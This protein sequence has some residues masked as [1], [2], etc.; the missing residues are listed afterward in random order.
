MN[1]IRRG[2]LSWRSQPERFSSPLHPRLLPRLAS[3]GGQAGP[4]PRWGEG[5][6]KVASVSRLFLLVAWIGLS[7]CSGCYTG[8]V[9][10]PDLKNLSYDREGVLRYKGE[11]VEG[12]KLK[13]PWYKEMWPDNAAEWGFTLVSAGLSA[14]VAS[15]GGGGGGGGG[16]SSGSTE[17]TVA[18]TTT[19]PSSGGGGGRSRPSTQ[20]TTT[21][22]AT[23]DSGGGGGGGGGGAAPPPAPEFETP[24][25]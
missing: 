5:E 6:E 11:E 23:S 13:L 18:T 22:T 17:P 12:I 10:R 9:N 16:S 21:S 1:F 14:A 2:G 8:I 7:V 24:S 20:S 19:A 4:L 15:G 3:E 25:F